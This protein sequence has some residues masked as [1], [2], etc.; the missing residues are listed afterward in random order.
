MEAIAD[1]ER[2]ITE[3]REMTDSPSGI[4]SR[5]AGLRVQRLNIDSKIERLLEDVTQEI[6][7]KDE[8]LQIKAKYRREQELICYEEESALREYEELKSTMSTAETW[9]T[10]IR[11]YQELPKIDRK[12][13]DAL[14]DEMQ[15]FES[16]EI[17]FKLTY[18]DPFKMLKAYLTSSKGGACHA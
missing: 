12:I 11:R 17:H 7:D 6:I 2:L 13:F 10:N 1:V 14:V 18:G 16:G 15:V 4:K 9:L 5:L 3:A 8:Y